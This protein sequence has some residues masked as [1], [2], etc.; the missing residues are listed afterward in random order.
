[1]GHHLKAQGGKKP[2]AFAVGAHLGEGIAAFVHGPVKLPGDEAH[3]STGGDF[4]VQL[5]HSAADQV[6]GIF[7]LR[8]LPADDLPEGGIG[9]DALPVQNQ[10]PGKGDALGQV[11][12][13]AG[14]VGDVLAHLAVAP[15]LGADEHPV[16][17]KEGRGEAV[18]FPH[19]AQGLAVEIGGK[20]PDVCG[21]PQGQQGVVVGHLLQLAHHGVAH[22][23]G[24]GVCVDNAGLLFQRR[25]F[26]KKRVVLL[27]GNQAF[28]FVVVGIPALIQPVYQ[29]F[30]FVH[31]AFSFPKFGGYKKSGL[32][33]Q[34]G[35]FGAG[36]GNRTRLCGLGSDHST[37]ELILHV[38]LAVL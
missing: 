29:F 7:I 13:G 18:H 3:A 34:A 32:R 16:P 6:P 33:K 17:V 21:F 36:Y 12:E 11:D 26:V 2:K 14:I 25:Q 27:I 28:V 19:Q 5:A 15:A 4:A 35:S 10:L 24:G 1:M 38:R 37:N 20:F 23:G 9:D 22:G 8:F 30:H 31:G